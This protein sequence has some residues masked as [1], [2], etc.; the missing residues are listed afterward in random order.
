MLFFKEIV[1]KKIADKAFHKLHEKECHVCLATVKVI[2]E[3]EK[4]KEDLDEILKKLHISEKAYKQLKE[5]EY[6]DPKLV[7]QLC[8]YFGFDESAQL[9]NCERS[10]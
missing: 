2:A 8:R 5:A 1:D 4:N 3:L 6:C 10:K 9:Q 7:R